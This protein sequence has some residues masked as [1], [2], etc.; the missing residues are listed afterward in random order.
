MEVKA[1]V[2]WDYLEL[3]VAGVKLSMLS[4]TVCIFILTVCIFIQYLPVVM[5]IAS[6]HLINYHEAPIC[7]YS[8]P[9]S[10]QSWLLYSSSSSVL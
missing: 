10:S 2:G 7:T 9:F 5:N 3:V 6:S 1:V 8:P 4:F